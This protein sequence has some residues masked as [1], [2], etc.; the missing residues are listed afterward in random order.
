MVMELLQGPTLKQLLGKGPLTPANSVRISMAI[1]AALQYIHQRHIC[2]IDLKPTNVIMVKE[3]GPV[4]VDLGLARTSRDVK[5][6][7]LTASH[8]LVGTPLYMAPEQFIGSQPDIRVDLYSLGIVMF[9]LLSGEPPW[10]EVTDF[11]SLAN[12]KS[13]EPQSVAKLKVSK[14]LRAVITK[15]LAPTPT[16]RYQS[17]R[18]LY[19][20]LAVCPEAKY[21]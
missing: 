11:R 21:D 3:R 18:E 15:S 20:A 12:Q 14:K 7:R 16:D 10:A 6:A 4:I 17:P 8:A 19:E 1:A 13:E 5:G 9:E 2:R